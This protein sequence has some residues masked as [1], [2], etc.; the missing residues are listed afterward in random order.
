MFTCPLNSQR[1]GQDS[2]CRSSEGTPQLQKQSFKNAAWTGLGLRG[3]LSPFFLT[4]SQTPLSSG[5][6][7]CHQ[8]TQET[9]KSQS[10]RWEGQPG[11]EGPTVRVRAGAVRGSWLP[12]GSPREAGMAA[13]ECRIGTQVPP[14]P[15]LPPTLLIL[16]GQVHG[17]RARW[18]PDRPEGASLAGSCGSVLVLSPADWS[19]CSGLTPQNHLYNISRSSFRFLSMLQRK[20]GKRL[21]A[22]A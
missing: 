4:L 16:P 5:V 19:S 13:G 10:Q 17:S 7:A 14:M 6:S 11:K 18:R 2:G 12:A 15:R 20:R 1:P 8:N 9:H 22:L 21:E 3:P